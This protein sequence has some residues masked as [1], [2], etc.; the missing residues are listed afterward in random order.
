MK[1]QREIWALGPRAKRSKSNS[2]AESEKAIQQRFTRSQKLL[3][4]REKYYKEYSKFL[5]QKQIQ[6]MYEIERQTMRNLQNHRGNR[7]H[8]NR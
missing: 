4:I 8:Y 6:R 2:E 3:D 1:Q 7:H 5:T